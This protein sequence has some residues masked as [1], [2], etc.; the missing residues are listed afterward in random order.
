MS[1]QI[2]EKL[3]EQIDTIPSL[4]IVVADALQVIDALDAGPKEL[5]AVLYKDQGLTTT[6]L[7]FANSAY[8]GFNRKI[9]TITEAIVI[10]GFNTIRSL[11]LAASVQRAVG[12]EV[13]GYDL[14]QGELWKHSI[15]CAMTARSIARRVGFPGVEQAFIAGLIH[16]IGKVIL[17]MHVASQF[18]EL[19]TIV[20]EQKLNFSQAEKQLFGADHAE[21]G[22][23]VAERWNLPEDLVDAIAHHHLI[24]EPAELKTITAVVHVADALCLMLGLGLGSD[25]LL[26]QVNSQAVEMLGLSDTAI[27]EIML[28]INDFAMDASIYKG[29]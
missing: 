2:L 24:E 8:Y 16:D 18:E 10:L 28:E 23:L 15:I 1:Q 11:L 20:S 25:G 3:V 21:I 17:S 19:M 27:Q 13:K 12:G 7:K 26:Y 9:S 14:A 4:P 22:G 29:I 5:A 6:I